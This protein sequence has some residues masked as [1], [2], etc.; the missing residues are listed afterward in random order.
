MIKDTI[1]KTIRFTQKELPQIKEWKVGG[2]YKVQIEITLENY[3][4]DI[5]DEEGLGGTFL[6]SGVKAIEEDKIK[7]LKEKFQ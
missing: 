3:G 4:N 1:K 5:W 6:V 7:K 2:K